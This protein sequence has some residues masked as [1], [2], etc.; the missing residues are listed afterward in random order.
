MPT[1]SWAYGFYGY[2][3]DNRDTYFATCRCCW[4]RPG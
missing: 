2:A 4:S 1:I 3:A